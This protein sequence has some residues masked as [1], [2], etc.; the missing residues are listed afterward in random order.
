MAVDKQDQ[1]FPV[2]RVDIEQQ[3]WTLSGPEAQGDVLSS[4]CHVGVHRGRWGTAVPAPFMGL[5]EDVGDGCGRL[6]V[7]RHLWKLES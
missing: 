6:E 3:S 2:E 7:G 1:V 4:Q 5:L